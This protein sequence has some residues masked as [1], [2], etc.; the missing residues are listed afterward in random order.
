MKIQLT[1][2]DD[3]SILGAQGPIEPHDVTVL[4]AGILKLFAGN[5]RSIILSLAN[6]EIGGEDALRELVRLGD[7]TQSQS[8]TVVLSG[9][10]ADLSQSI[11]RLVGKPEIK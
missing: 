5:T 11:T 7:I 9:V 6:S 3:I 10:G 2:K 4:K 8:G 1:K